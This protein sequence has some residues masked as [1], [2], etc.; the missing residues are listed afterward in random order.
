M[1][2][3]LILNI[4]DSYVG[5]PLVAQIIH[6]LFWGLRDKNPKQR[7]QYAFFLI[8]LV[9]LSIFLIPLHQRMDM[10]GE[11]YFHIP[12]VLG[13]L[14]LGLYHLSVYESGKKSRFRR[15]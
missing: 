15:K 8:G 6:A 10:L 5:F 3:E 4:F 12:M 7:D 14:G 13:G 9:M 11:G 2:M 1:T